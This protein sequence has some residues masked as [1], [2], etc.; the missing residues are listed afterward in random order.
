MKNIKEEIMKTIENLAHEWSIGKVDAT[1]A[2]HEIY[3]LMGE[4]TESVSTGLRESCVL[5][6]DSDSNASRSCEDAANR[7][8]DI[9]T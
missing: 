4:N 7:T 2:M 3:S 1:T 9:N 5:H 8:F 6:D